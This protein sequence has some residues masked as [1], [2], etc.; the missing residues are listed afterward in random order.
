MAA[1][2]GSLLDVSKTGATA[3][4]G[5]PTAE[6]S[7]IRITEHPLFGLGG[8]QQGDGQTGGS[9]LDT[10]AS[11]PARVQVAPWQASASGSQGPTRHA[12]SSAAVAK[13]DLPNIAHAGVL[14]SNSEASHSG[15]KSS[16]TAVTEGFQ[17][18]ILDAIRLVL[19]HSEVS[20]ENGGHSYLVGL[21]GTELGTDD[22]LGA[23]PLC[24]LD[25]AGLLSLSCLSASGGG[26]T[27]GSGLTDAAAQ[28]AQITPA[29][30]ALSIIDPV[31][32]FTSAASAGTGEAAAAPAPEANT[33]QAAETSRATAPAAAGTGGSA[34][35]PRTG[36]AIASLAASAVT[37]LLFGLALRRFRLRPTKVVS[38]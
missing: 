29:V 15:P 24:A 33:T 12:R 35:L 25:A 27:A 36:T 10:Q 21:N 18:G 16:G 28:V 3:D 17:L 34:A 20:S 5:T 8:S 26:G 4:S 22:Q 13:A 32:A 2:V 37:M 9:L 31:A 19:L 38:N 7:V 1:Q 6:A 23:S 11:L 14:T 30:E